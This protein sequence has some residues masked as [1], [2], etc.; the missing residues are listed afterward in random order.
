MSC[1]S[2]NVSAM[3]QSVPS[4]ARLEDPDP[5]LSRP[6]NPLAV[7]PIAGT[8]GPRTISRTEGTLHSSLLAE[9]AAQDLGENDPHWN[10][11]GAS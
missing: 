4:S 8:L 5:T 9:D 10:A 11:A 7:F 6:P 2:A 1:G 3:R